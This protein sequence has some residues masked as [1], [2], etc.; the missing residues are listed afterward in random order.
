MPDTRQND[1]P[2][3]ENLK[4]PEQDTAQDLPRT[5]TGGQTDSGTGLNPGGGGQS[6]SGE[7]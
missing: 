6:R 3:N 4:Q 1:T 2:Q 5:R 7:K